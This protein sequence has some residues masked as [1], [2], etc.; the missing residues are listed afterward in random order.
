MKDNWRKKKKKGNSTVRLTRIV[1]SNDFG[2]KFRTRSETLFRLVGCVSVA[3]ATKFH[4]IYAW[5]FN[6]K[7][8][9]VR[10]SIF[11][12]TAKGFPRLSC[13]SKTG[14]LLNFGFHRARSEGPYLPIVHFRIRFLGNASSRREITASGSVLPNVLDKYR[15][16]HPFN[17]IL[18][19]RLERVFNQLLLLATFYKI[20]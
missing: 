8:C 20:I 9:F 12:I 5:S 4:S 18:N 15:P 10:A 6:E 7:T 14:K 13:G 2:D 1:I 16:L 3:C 11:R 19:D 17:I